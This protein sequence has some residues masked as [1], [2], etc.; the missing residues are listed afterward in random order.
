[1]RFTIYVRPEAQHQ[2]SAAGALK[3]GLERHGH[4]ANFTSI[5]GGPEGDVLVTWG[6]RKGVQLSHYGLPVLVMERAYVADRFVWHSFGWNGLNGNARFHIEDDGGDRWRKH[7][8]GYLKEPRTT[9]EYAVIMGQVHGDASIINVPDLDG[10]Y[11]KAYHHTGKAIGLP[12]YFRDHPG[13]KRKWAE[14]LPRIDGDLDTVLT[15]AKLVIAYNSN[16]LVDAR[17]SGISI[18][19]GNTGTMAWPVANTMSDPFRE[20]NLEKWTHDLAWTQWLLEEVRCG[21]AI[22][23]ILRGMDEPPFHTRQYA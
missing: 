4:T 22:P 16:S 17:L 1:M 15:K 5:H 13:A 18:V 12:V 20:R 23:F 8:A 21:D 9:G 14:D 6:W 11:R 19:A 2:N 7:F 10:W 3:E